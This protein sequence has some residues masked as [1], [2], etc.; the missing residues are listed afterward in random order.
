MHKIKKIIRQNIDGLSTDLGAVIVNKNS[1]EKRKHERKPTN[2]EVELVAG[3]KVDKSKAKDVSVCGIF[4]KNQDSDSYK[5]DESIVLAFESK[6]GEPHTIEGKI[7]RKDNEGIGIRF[8]EEL[9]TIAL[10][11]AEEWL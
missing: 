1:T 8:K 10:K 6:S 5:V 4:I 7:V 3:G 9:I 2:V 11:H